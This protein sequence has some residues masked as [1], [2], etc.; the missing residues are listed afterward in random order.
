MKLLGHPDPRIL[1]RELLLRIAAAHPPDGRASTLVLVPTSRLAAH[2]QRRLATTSAR[3]AWL[4]VD[5]RTFRVTTTAIL[6][7][8]REP[9]PVLLSER[10]RLALVRRVLDAQPSNPWAGYVKKRPGAASRVGAAFQD[11]REAGIGADDLRAAEAADQASTPMADLY[12]AYT[13]ILDAGP[14]R[15]FTD[16]AGLVRAAIPWAADFARAHGAVFLHGAYELLGIHVDLLRALDKGTEVTV[17]VPARRSTKATRYA[18]AFAARFLQREG[19]RL[20]PIDDAGDPGCGL[21]LDA[22]YD[23]P[24]RPAPTPPGRVSFRSCQGAHAE[25]E[26]AVRHALAAIAQGCPPQEIAIVARSLEP[27]ASAIESMLAE[28]RIPFTST[29]AT[30]LRRRPIVRDL[31]LLLRVVAEDF[32]RAPT[33]ELLR[34]P[35]V[36][37]RALA[38]DGRPPQGARADVFSRKARIVGGIDE[39]TV[40]LPRW[41]EEDAARRARLRPDEA[42]SGWRIE[43]AQRIGATLSR[44]RARVAPA[45]RSWT[46]HA[47]RIRT[48]ATELLTTGE[49]EE[50]SAKIDELLADMRRLESWL[51]DGRRVS[52]AEALG[53]LDQATD[54]TEHVPHRDDAGG[55]RVLD[56]LQARGL[57]FER[58][59]VLGM[60]AGVFP[61]RGADDPVLGDALRLRLRE[62]TSRPLP[63]TAAGPD[64]E[65]LLLLLL[66]GAS[67]ES[68]E[69]SWQ[70]A[71][72]VGRVRSP[73]L[74]LREVA[75]IARGRPDLAEATPVEV[76]SHP[77]RWLRYAIE[78]PR[79]LSEAERILLRALAGH[80]RRALDDLARTE[81][82][83][84]DGLRTVAATDSFVI[85]DPAFDGRLGR[86]VIPADGLSVSALETLGR[87]PLQF[88]FA[89]V[90]R[91]HEAEDE[92]DALELEPRELGSEVHGRLADLYRTLAADGMLDPAR[93]DE[94]LDR[95]RQILDPSHGEILGSLGERMAKRF[96]I[97]WQHTASRWHRAILGFVES[98]LRRVAGEGLSLVDVELSSEREL[99]L[100]TGATLSVRGRLDRVLRGA[101]GPIV[102]DYKTGRSAKRLEDGT[103]TTQM[104]KGRVL[105][106]PLY[107]HLARATQVELLGIN[108]AFEEGVARGTFAGFTEP[109]T[110][111]GFIETLQALLDLLC[112]GS[113]PLRPGDPC[114]YCSFR[115]ACRHEHPPTVVRNTLDSDGRTCA[116]LGRKT[117]RKPL[118]AMVSRDDD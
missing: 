115:G 110:Q 76:P 112:R 42:D 81:P 92:V 118:L 84:A 44:L 22:L 78:T 70:R 6:D 103:S 67:R 109:R 63:L 74:A 97:L 72:E 102:G 88:F 77:E 104:L 94:A 33:A 46:E 111:E 58:V 82:S 4:G 69:L 11:L 83:L 34:S 96:P 43:E 80:G 32:P 55:L 71:A 1:E 108:P 5:V 30:P 39:W 65:R 41:A 2:V 106:V 60:N 19:A 93:L 26:T 31:L 73:S 53:W 100:R 117:E 17:L 68:V 91:V 9:T 89:R 21:A 98:D 12:S 85:V 29:V 36:R 40:G 47:D 16:E 59:H 61:R 87:C 18:E 62:T 66:L 45:P 27:Y 95:A 15:G 49:A 75:R 3:R 105:Q 64:E 54:A 25:V 99:P 24:S 13:D 101:K 57:T 50:D 107:L 14:A 114:T 56:A 28:A 51:G 52:F 8:A 10:M 79:A 113:F 38:P 20:A 86:S 90:L 35:R 48:V 116:A 23:E 7:R 37:L